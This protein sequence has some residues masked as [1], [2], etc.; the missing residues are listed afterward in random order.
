MFGNS[1]IFLDKYRQ[2]SI[3]ISV[4]NLRYLDVLRKK[5]KYVKSTC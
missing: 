4:N 2:S 3:I 1:V 5:D